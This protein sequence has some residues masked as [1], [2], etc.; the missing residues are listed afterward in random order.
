MVLLYGLKLS[1]YQE[2]KLELQTKGPSMRKIMLY[3]CLQQLI[4]NLDQLKVYRYSY[5]CLCGMGFNSPYITERRRKGLLLNTKYAVLRFTI[6]EVHHTYSHTCVC[7]ITLSMSVRWMFNCLGNVSSIKILAKAM[8]KSV[9]WNN[10]THL[11]R[12]F[13]TTLKNINNMSQLSA[14]CLLLLS[15]A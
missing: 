9:V 8:R 6:K 10:S 11:I 14:T 5:F 4:W 1:R 13:C 3:M 7:G 12:N 2:Q 15:G